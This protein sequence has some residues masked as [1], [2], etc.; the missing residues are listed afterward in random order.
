MQIIEAPNGKQHLT[1]LAPEFAAQFEVYGCQPVQGFGEVH[2]RDLY[3]RAKYDEWSFEVADRNGNMP[4]DG[5][6]DSD[7]YYVERP[8]LNA[9]YMPHREAVL[10]IEQS[11]RAYTDARR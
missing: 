8:Y 7:G 2:G 11:L 3:F 4:S 6:H 1:V 9:G 10:L 5:F